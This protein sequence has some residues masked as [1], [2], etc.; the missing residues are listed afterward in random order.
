M[1]GIKNL[2]IN[3]YMLIDESTY[4]QTILQVS[5]FSQSVTNQDI[6]FLHLFIYSS[7]HL[8]H[9]FQSL[10]YLYNALYSLFIQ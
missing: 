8:F 2:I 7:I 6:D 5:H 1:M 3:K 9:L 10:S 4:K